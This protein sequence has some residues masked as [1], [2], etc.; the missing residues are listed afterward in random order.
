MINIS[1]QPQILRKQLLVEMNMISRSPWLI[2][3]NSTFFSPG[4]FDLIPA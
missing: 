3:S 4:V 2:F 1:T